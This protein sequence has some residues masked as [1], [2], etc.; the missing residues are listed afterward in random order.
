L[1]H[2]GKQQR[3]EVFGRITDA[4]GAKV[5]QGQAFEDLGSLNKRILGRA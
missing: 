1:G 3:T 4:I 5:Y 2:L